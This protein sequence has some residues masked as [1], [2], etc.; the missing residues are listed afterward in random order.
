[1]FETP[2]DAKPIINLNVMNIGN[3]VEK[4]ANVPTQQKKKKK[5]KIEHEYAI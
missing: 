4:V 3:D 5:L 1:M 2:I